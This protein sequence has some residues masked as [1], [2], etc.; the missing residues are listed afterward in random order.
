VPTIDVV[1]ESAHSVTSA[2]WPVA[3]V[4]A[5]G[6]VAVSGRMTAAEVGTVLATMAVYEGLVGREDED[7]AAA[8]AEDLVR[9]LV[10]AEELSAPGGLRLRDEGTGAE[11][12]PGCC[13]GVKD[14]REW[15]DLAD[16]GEG[17]WLGHDPAPWCERDGEVLRVWPDGPLAGVAP[18]GAVGRPVEVGL[19]ELPG[20]LSGVRADLRG[21]LARTEEWAARHA[22][23]LGGS[24]IAKLDAEL[25][26]SGEERLPG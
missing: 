13:S 23:G 3:D 2:P 20:L 14:W 21:F 11:V 8:G 7:E 22:A 1:L 5:F 24:L 19:A 16:G 15:Y 17:P 26:I 10:A 4:R 9:G 25:R 12:V 6:W 18:I